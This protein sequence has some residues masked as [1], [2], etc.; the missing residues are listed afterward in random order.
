MGISF[1]IKQF[2]LSLIIIIFNI[3]FSICYI[4]N[5]KNYIYF[6]KN[7]I[8]IMILFSISFLIDNFL[9]EFQNLNCEPI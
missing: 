1:P 2:I 7:K 4:L 8:I 5:Q 6:Q 3:L 9:I